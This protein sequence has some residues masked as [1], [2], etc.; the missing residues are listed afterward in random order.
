V[1][2]QLAG[3][4]M[5]WFTGHCPPHWFVVQHV[6]VSGQYHALAPG[7]PEQPTQLPL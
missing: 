5:H 4:P 2:G 6:A 1:V 3:L 7:V